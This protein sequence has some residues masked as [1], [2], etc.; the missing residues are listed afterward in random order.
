MF[1]LKYINHLLEGVQQEKF[2]NFYDALNE[3]N[4]LLEPY[5][6]PICIECHVGDQPLILSWEIHKLKEWGR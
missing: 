2:D 5:V 4:S 1:V 6:V 3:G